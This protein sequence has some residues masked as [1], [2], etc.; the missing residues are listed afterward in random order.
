VPGLRVN[1]WCTSVRLGMAMKLDETIRGQFEHY[2]LFYECSEEYLAGCTEFI[3]AGLASGER[4]LI[5][6]PGRKIEPMRAALNGGSDKV[7]F[8]NM[9]EIGHNPG[10][11]IPAVRDWVDRGAGRCRFIGEPIWPGRTTAEVIRRPATRR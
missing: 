6:V 4:V 10:R 9:N 2:A 8:W 11:I 5:S 7:E 1:E 3:E